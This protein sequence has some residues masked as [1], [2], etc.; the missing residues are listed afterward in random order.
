[1]REHMMLSTAKTALT[2]LAIQQAVIAGAQQLVV[3]QGPNHPDA[4][5][6]RQFAHHG[7]AVFFYYIGD[8]LRTLGHSAKYS[9][10]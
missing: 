10:L 8:F 2:G 3:V 5:L 7:R 9:H 1:M 6:V 4:A